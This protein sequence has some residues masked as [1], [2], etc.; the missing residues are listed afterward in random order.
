MRPASGRS[1]RPAR[2]EDYDA[3]AA[4]IDQWWGRP[5]LGSLPRLFFDLFHR[6]SLVIDGAEGPAAFLAGILSP[7]DPRQ[8]YIHFAGVDP[9]TRQRGLGRVLY[10]AFFALARADGRSEVRAVTSPANTGSVAFHQSMG[11]AVTGPV[12]GYNGPGRDFIVFHRSL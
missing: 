2:R 10:E 1:P 6:T 12:P 11:F 5:V 9:G 3:I 8:A 4:V 7:S